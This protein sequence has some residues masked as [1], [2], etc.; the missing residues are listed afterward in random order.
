MLKYDTSLESLKPYWF[1]LR[2]IGLI[3]VGIRVKSALELTYTQVWYIIG[4]VSSSPTDFHSEKIGLIRVTYDPPVSIRVNKYLKWLI[5][6]CDTSF[7]SSAH[8]L[9][10]YT[11]KTLL[12]N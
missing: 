10:I 12:I 3:R 1:P 9:Q 11:Q 7:E 2:K 6:K 8:A 4:I 5:L